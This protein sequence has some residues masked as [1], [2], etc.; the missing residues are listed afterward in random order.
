MSMAKGCCSCP[1]AMCVYIN[2]MMLGITIG[3][4]KGSGRTF[5]VDG[6]PRI[7]RIPPPHMATFTNNRAFKNALLIFVSFLCN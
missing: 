6:F 7:L 4:W 3:M 5:K 1:W 2:I